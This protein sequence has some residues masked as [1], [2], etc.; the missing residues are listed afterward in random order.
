V[1]SRLSF[2][3]DRA[4]AVFLIVALALAGLGLVVPDVF[5]PLDRFF[6]WGGADLIG[7]RGWMYLCIA[8]VL[9]AVAGLVGW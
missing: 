6:A 4:F 8:A 5:R 7:V 2:R 1:G 3:P 9:G